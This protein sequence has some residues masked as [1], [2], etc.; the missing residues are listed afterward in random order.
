V[1]LTVLPRIESSAI[2]GP[3]T[4]VELMDLAEQI[5]FDL[6][7]AICLYN[8]EALAYQLGVVETPDREDEDHWWE[9]EQ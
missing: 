9:E 2:V 5:L 8:E 4:F 7:E 1:C 3:F 6:Q